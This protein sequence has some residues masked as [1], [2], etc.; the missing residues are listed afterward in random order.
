MTRK[1]LGD[2]EIPNVRTSSEEIANQLARK[3]LR[4]ELAPGSK[5]P[6]ERELAIQFG[7]PD[8][9]IEQARAH[10]AHHLPEYQPF[11]QAW[12]KMM[13]RIEH[14]TSLRQALIEAL[15]LGPV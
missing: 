13:E 9:I 12:G 1:Q 10:A 5:L 14:E 6:P 8:D 4:R 7:E 2:R 15:Q 3:L 11:V